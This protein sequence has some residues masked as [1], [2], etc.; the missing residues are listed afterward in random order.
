[1]PYGVVPAGDAVLFFRRSVDYPAA[2]SHYASA[3]NHLDD[4]SNGTADDLDPRTHTHDAVAANHHHA[5]PGDNAAGRAVRGRGH[6]TAIRHR[7]PERPLL[8][9]DL[10]RKAILHVQSVSLLVQD[11]ANRAVRTIR[12]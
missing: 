6:Q 12:K 4:A 7:L 8:Q 10:H 9:D 1:M 2:S 3:A 11:L 5:A